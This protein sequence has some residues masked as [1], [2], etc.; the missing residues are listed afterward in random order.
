MDK[1]TKLTGPAC[2]IDQ[3]NLNTDQ[4]LPA[5]YLKWTRCD[6]HREG[7]VPGPSIR[8]GGERT[9]GFPDQPA[10]VAQCEDR[11]RGAEL[12]VWLLARGRGLCALRLWRSLRDRAVLWRHLLRQRHSERT[13][14]SHCDR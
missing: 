4:I 3:P 8:L 6:G 13:A 9:V 5:R 14:D 7:A 12:R 1:F 11:G 10:G 2:P